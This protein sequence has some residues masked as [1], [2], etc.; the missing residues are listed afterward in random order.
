[1]VEK[2][3]LKHNKNKNPFG[4][5]RGEKRGGVEGYRWKLGGGETGQ[6]KGV[7]RLAL[8]GPSWG[9]TPPSRPQSFLP[10][11]LSN[12]YD[13]SKEDQQFEGI[14]S[15]FLRNP[16]KKRVKEVPNLI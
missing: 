5:S 3:T 15:T 4:E 14:N 6:W 2:A 1:M 13:A 9:S 10:K 16:S 12:G 8:G 11:G 7:R